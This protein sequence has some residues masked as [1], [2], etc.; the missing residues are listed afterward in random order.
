MFKRLTDGHPKIR[1]TVDGTA[2]EASAGESVA[3]LL[4]AHGELVFRTTPVSKSPRGAYCMIGNCH[5]CLV[6]IDG[7][8]NRQGCRV[9]AV[10]GMDIRRQSGAREVK[11]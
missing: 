6:E 11:R 5:D 1:V 4:L 8:Q 10:D 2:V 7:V 3:A 9:I